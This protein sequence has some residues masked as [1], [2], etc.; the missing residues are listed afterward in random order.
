MDYTNERA[1]TKTLEKIE[2]SLCEK[3]HVRK[4]TDKL[5]FTV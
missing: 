2:E 4:C 5:D 3:N 1:K